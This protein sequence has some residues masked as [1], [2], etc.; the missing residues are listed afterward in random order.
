[1]NKQQMQQKAA[2]QYIREYLSD[3]NISEHIS[4]IQEDVGNKPTVYSCIWRSKTIDVIKTVVQ[5]GK[6]DRFRFNDMGYNLA[7]DKQKNLLLCVYLAVPGDDGCLLNYLTADGRM[8]A[9]LLGSENT[10]LDEI[11]HLDL[12]T[13]FM[14]GFITAFAGRNAKPKSNIIIPGENA[15][16]SGRIIL[17]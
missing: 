8:G 17:P 13:T 4:T 7:T 1:M 3:T 10:K 15:Q 5:L 2:K 11:V 6:R 16:G 14:E 9:Y 12:L